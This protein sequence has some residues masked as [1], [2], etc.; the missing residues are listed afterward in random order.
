M[1]SA[2]GSVVWAAIDP[3][4]WVYIVQDGFEVR[5]EVTGATVT[6]AQLTDAQWTRMFPPGTTVTFKHSPWA[7]LAI[8]L[9]PKTYEVWNFV[10]G[11]Q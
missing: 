1:K 10:C 5:V 9:V 11:L 6:P 8:A 7:N 4:S 3:E 2:F